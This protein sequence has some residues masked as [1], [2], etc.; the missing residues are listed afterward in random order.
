MVGTSWNIQ[1]PETVE[2]LIDQVER[3]VACVNIKKNNN[4]DDVSFSPGEHAAIPSF[5]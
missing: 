5:L 2:P 1:R 3:S 4:Q